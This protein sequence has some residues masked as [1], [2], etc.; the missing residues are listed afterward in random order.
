MRFELH[1]KQMSGKAE[2]AVVFVED[3]DDVIRDG[4]T[5]R[6]KEVTCIIDYITGKVSD[7]KRFV[8]RFF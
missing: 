6:T 2:S 4:V 8:Q 1:S 7:T 5:I 3:D